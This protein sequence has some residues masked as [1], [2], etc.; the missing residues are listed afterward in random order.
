MGYELLEPTVNGSNMCQDDGKQKHAPMMDA[1]CLRY[2][3]KV[4]ERGLEPVRVRTQ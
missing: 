4:H 3:I 1:E 2:L